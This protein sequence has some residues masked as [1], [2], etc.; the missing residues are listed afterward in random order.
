MIRFQCPSCQ[1]VLEVSDALANQAISCFDCGRKVRVPLVSQNIVHKSWSGSIHSMD[2]RRRASRSGFAI[3]LMILGM[4]LTTF[5]GFITFF[6]WLL[7]QTTV[8]DTGLQNPFSPS[9]EYVHN[10]GS[11]NN[12]TVGIT[13]GVGLALGGLLLF[14]TGYLGDILEW[15]RKD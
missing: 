15:S 6:Y 11:M 12:R 9:I 10:I 13:V 14:V 2:T 4:L 8:R 1:T 5:G 7:Y 3:F